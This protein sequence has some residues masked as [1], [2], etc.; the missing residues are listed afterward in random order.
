MPRRPVAFRQADLKRALSAAKAA[1]VDIDRVE[2][3]PATGKITMTVR[4][5]AANLDVAP[6][7]QWLASHARPS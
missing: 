2:I 7:D 3:D 1:G 4:G 6:L 5:G